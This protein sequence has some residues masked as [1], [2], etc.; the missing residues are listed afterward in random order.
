MTSSALKNSAPPTHFLFVAGA[1]RERTSLESAQL[2]LGHQLWGLRTALIR[3][4]LTKYVGAE[5][6]GWVYALKVG[7]CAGFRIASGVLSATELSDFVREDLRA[8]TAYGFV[9][10]ADVRSWASSPETSL[11]VLRRV[12]QV[13]DPAE[14]SRRL[15]LGMHGLTQAQHRAIAEEFGNQP[16]EAG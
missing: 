16:K 7:V 10:V 15:S 2:Q 3:E 11:E 6:Y 9:R 14:L 8:E 4:N 5:S 12:L 13:Q 1:L